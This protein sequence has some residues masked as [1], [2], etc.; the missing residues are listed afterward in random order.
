MV[1]QTSFAA[2][3]SGEEGPFSVLPLASEPFGTHNRYRKI[4]FRRLC[5]GIVFFGSGHRSSHSG[6][7]RL[8][9]GSKR[10]ASGGEEHARPHRRMSLLLRS[11]VMQDINKPRPKRFTSAVSAIAALAILPISASAQSSPPTQ[12]LVGYW[13]FD[14]N[15][16]TI[17][18]DSSG[19]GYNGAVNGAQWVT[20]KINSALS[21][22]GT[23]S[24][25]ATG[26]IPLQ[27]A[28]SIVAWVN[29][30]T[31][32]QTPFGRIAETQYNVGFFLGL[33]ATG[34]AY[35][36]IVNGGSGAT[37]KCGSAYGCALG[38]TVSSGWHLVIGTYNGNMATLYVDNV[39]VAT[40]TFT[41]PSAQSLPL[42]I[43]R[44]FGGSA[45]GWSGGIDEVRLYNRALTAAEASAIFSS[46]TIPDTTPPQISIT[47]PASGA[48]VSG[49]VQLTAVATDNVGVTGVQFQLDNTTKLGGLLTGAGPTYSYTWDTT[50]AT[51]GNHTLTATASDAAGNQASSSIP[52][53]V[54]N[55][56]PVIS[57]VSAGSITSA[58]ATITWTTDQPSTSQVAYGTSTS[59][60]S[61]TALNSSLVTSHSVV[62]TGLSSSTVYNFEV[63][64]QNAQGTLATSTNF[65]FTTA[66]SSGPPTSGLLGYWR[67]DEDLGTVAD[68]SSGH[69]YNGTINGAA[70]V[71]GKI[72]S[73]L[74][75]NGT[76][77]EVVTGNIPLQNAF[78]VSAWVNP[79]ATAQTPF[80]RI[81]ETQYSVG[82]YL[83]MNATGT[84]YKFIVSGGAG[85]TGKCQASYG[86]AEG[87]TVSS[88]WHLLTAT[89]DGANAALYVD[90]AQVAAETFAPPSNQNLPLYIGQ[91]F[92]GS[93]YGWNGAIDEV[94]L[95]NRALN[96][97]EVVSI[98]GYNGGPP[99]TTPPSLPGNLTA[100]PLSPTAITVSWSASS[101]S[102]GVAG[103]ELYRNGILVTTTAALSY[104]DTGLIPST[105]YSYTVA[106]YDI[107]G[108]ISQQTSPVA[109]T[110][111]APSVSNVSAINVSPTG[112]II[113]WSTNEPAN[114]QLVYGLTSA[115]GT[116]PLTSSGLTTAHAI[117][118]SGL[119]ASTTYH[120]QVQSQDALGNVAMSGDNMFTTAATPSYPLGW[121]QLP[122]TAYNNVCPPDF[123][124]NQPYAFASQCWR[125]IVWGGAVADT[126][127]NRLLIWGGGHDNYYG[128]EIYALNLNAKPAT[129]TRLTNP[130]PIVPVGGA[131]CPSALS[132]GNPDARET[133]NNIAYVANLDLMFSFNGALACGNG[134]HL[135]DTWIL[136]TA[137]MQW[138]NMNP[139]NGPITSTTYGQY[140]A[141]TGYDPSNQ[142]IYLQWS[143][144]FFEYAYANNT[145]TLLA[146]GT[147][148]LPVYA[149]GAVDPKRQKLF[150]M[151]PEFQST[152]PQIYMIDLTGA[153]SYS[154]VNI[155]AQVTGCNAL[156]SAPYP[157]FVYDSALDKI[158]G[159]PNQGNT[160]YIFDPATLTCTQQT[161]PN[162]PV[163]TPESITQGTF[164][165]FQ[166]FPALD[167]FAVVNAGDDNAYILRIP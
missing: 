23:S 60:G 107:V 159:W 131:V 100:K 78:S 149:T 71:T 39:Q 82:L 27:N 25:V 3:T 152:V 31:T 14:E 110:T 127:R 79:A 108:N 148:H 51:G 97:A 156:A 10:G 75:F 162:G 144:A 83:G 68:D 86:C 90:Q 35:Q 26:N 129:M 61:T 17:A 166:Y 6:G 49:T 136:N 5:L 4:L 154:S 143:D 66:V 142:A 2:D 158:V 141:V 32:S 58:G 80:G 118:V 72:N 64:S 42:F 119:A 9:P 160:V 20:G 120:F 46:G 81:L 163:N 87:G 91:Y 12:G 15:T 37:G 101:D 164:G 40:E 103:Y 33:S 133:Q 52:I 124:N 48:T 137:T 114:G 95:Y 56:P 53:I 50:I 47:A 106:A 109:A 76:T 8:R 147:S 69:G 77:N 135:N 1:N 104:Q 99:D 85:A 116:G 73:A 150:A 54:S 13:N 126:L 84:A 130:S 59:Y 146:N 24:Y 132:D 29:P 151:G 155:T 65:T 113:T 89:F 102:T 21:F 140:F 63:L 55:I 165:R 7:C 45:Y 161:Y 41:P 11:G 125:L 134:D 36:L 94:R 38:G 92:A 93:G 67:F 88:G 96:S 62:L 117:T 115:Y 122:N 138:Q 111:L 43:G 105:L 19:N 139:T 30:A 157:G 70:W 74:K 128:N 167:A 28:F 98:Y 34:G 16:G 145:Y 22:N 57:G 18:H 112:A 123:Y 44:Y 121:T 153:G